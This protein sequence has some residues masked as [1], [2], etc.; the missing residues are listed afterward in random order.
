VHLV[1]LFKERCA[2]KGGEKRQNAKKNVTSVTN[3]LLIKS[4]E[5]RAWFEEGEGGRM[6]AC[7]AC[8]LWGA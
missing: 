6:E 5:S 1:I 2:T 3:E 4:G 8:S 7:S